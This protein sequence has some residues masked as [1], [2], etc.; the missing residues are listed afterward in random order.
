MKSGFQNLESHFIQSAAIKYDLID[1]IRFINH[2]GSFEYELLDALLGEI[3]DR[4]MS[5]YK[6]MALAV[7]RLSPNRHFIA[8]MQ[9]APCCR[10]AV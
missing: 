9:V 7:L 8:L 4:N 6:H 1:Q 3:L 10:N 2:F 5:G